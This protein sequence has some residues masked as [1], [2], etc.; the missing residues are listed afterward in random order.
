[1]IITNHREVWQW[2][3][4]HASLLVNGNKVHVISREGYP[5]SFIVKA[6]VLVIY[7]YKNSTE[8]LYFDID[9]QKAFISF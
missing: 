6:N 7:D 9:L 2:R 8:A 1:M 3:G 5:I 4:L